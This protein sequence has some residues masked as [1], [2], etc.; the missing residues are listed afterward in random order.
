M[1][2]ERT[3][4]GPCDQPTDLNST[5]A[6]A[7]PSQDTPPPPESSSLVS[8]VTLT[9]HF[10]LVVF[11]TLPPT[12]ATLS[13]FLRRQE[14]KSLLV[15]GRRAKDWRIQQKKKCREKMDSF[16]RLLSVTKTERRTGGWSLWRK[17]A[18]LPLLPQPTV[19]TRGRG[20]LQVEH[21]MEE[22]GETQ[23]KQMET[24]KPS[25]PRETPC[26]H[27]IPSFVCLFVKKQFV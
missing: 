3:Q 23:E 18:G 24:E 20:N 1:P 15:E 5:L 4:D 2:R 16:P 17:G 13:D 12:P 25:G 19:R 14:V 11:F 26:L 8:P 22:G 6:M 9:P 27:A 21:M 7:F 10:L